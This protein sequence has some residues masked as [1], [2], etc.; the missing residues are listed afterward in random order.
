MRKSEERRRRP[1][2]RGPGVTDAGT[3]WWLVEHDGH[4]AFYLRALMAGDFAPG[5]DGPDERHVLHLDGKAPTVGQA[6]KCGTCHKTMK[7]E[8]LV[9]VERVTGNR[10]ALDVF[11]SRRAAW[12]KKTD[13]TSCYLCGQRK[14]TK[15][16]TDE[17]IRGR[18]VP[19][20]RN[21]N[22]HVA[23][24]KGKDKWLG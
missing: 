19:L 3:W 14:A 8:D 6:L 4:E 2:G 11:R 21:C 12:P 17:K 1:G 9:P 13:P 7:T 18:R 22:R 10:R 20:C 15:R 23:G 5:G 16:S 24:R